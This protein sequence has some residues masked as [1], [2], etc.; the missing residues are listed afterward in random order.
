MIFVVEEFAFACVAPSSRSVGLLLQSAR[1]EAV[2]FPV[3]PLL[4]K[5][6]RSGTPATVS[7]RCKRCAT[8]NHRITAFAPD[9]ELGS[10]GQCAGDSWFSEIVPG[11]AVDFVARHAPLAGREDFHRGDGAE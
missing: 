8:Q 7:Q 11:F 4:A 5:A 1:L 6:A 2:P 3:I 9:L 10:L